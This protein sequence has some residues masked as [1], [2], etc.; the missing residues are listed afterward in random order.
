MS[1]RPEG[2]FLVFLVKQAFYPQILSSFFCA[3]LFSPL[4]WKNSLRLLRRRRNLTPLIMLLLQQLVEQVRLFPFFCRHPHYS[5][6]VRVEAPLYPSFLCLLLEQGFWTSALL[7]LWAGWFF[8]HKV[9]VGSPLHFMV[10][11]I[12]GHCLLRA[13]SAPP[14]L[15]CDNQECLQT[16]PSVPQRGEV[17]TSW[18][19][20]RE[21]SCCLPAWL[22]LPSSTLP[23]PSHCWSFACPTCCSPGCSVPPTELCKSVSVTFLRREAFSPFSF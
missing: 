12:H 6:L 21:S 22:I 19:A 10:F 2:L 7:A 8:F 20:L 5:M 11:S 4:V 18:E 16:L 14:L 3:V 17:A 15:S 1:V 13:R 9:G 23:A